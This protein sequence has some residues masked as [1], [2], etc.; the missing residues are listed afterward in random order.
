MYYKG[1]S[2]ST[3]LFLFYVCLMYISNY[4]HAQ[5]N[6]YKYNI[7]LQLNDGW[8]VASLSEHGIDTREIESTTSQFL[9]EDRYENVLSMLI[10]KN[11]KLVHEA[12]SPYVQ[13]NTLHWMA[14]I[15][16]A[17]TS[18]LIGIAIDK[19]FIE[20]VNSGVGEL[21]PEFIDAIS[22]PEFHKIELKHLMTMSSG[23]E[24]SERS[25]YND[26]HNSE[27]QMVDSQDWIRFVL[28]KRVNNEPGTHFLYNTGGIHLLSAV[29]KS[30]TGLYAHEFAEKYLL[31]PLGIRA[32]QWNRDPMGYPCTGGT[33]GGIGLRTRDVAKF[34]WLFLKD[35]TWQGKQIISQK[36][37]KEATKNHKARSY[38]RNYYGY[39]WSPGS[40]T[41]NG[42]TFD[43]IAAFGYG[44]QILYL[45]PEMDLIIV[46]TCELTEGNANVHTLVEKT[47]K[48]L[49]QN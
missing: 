38:G 25:S 26:L 22:D 41:V 37:I 49:I 12:Y 11:G 17:F 36:W 16:K 46:F 7:P 40:K 45:V 43:Y 28:S 24:W 8:E 13:R 35:G 1:K 10:V 29:I 27:H 48:A 3:N 20:S 39:N 30:T 23:L 6:D 2:K 31:H 15:T 5:T 33:D 9:A 19:G 44:G 32:Y 18:T 47:F 34:G 21:L 42:K 14:S 4:V